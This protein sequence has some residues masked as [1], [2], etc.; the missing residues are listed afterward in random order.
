MLQRQKRMSFL[1]QIVTED[2]KW[3]YFENPK[4]R[5][6][7]LIQMNCQHARPNRFG[8]KTTLCVWWDQA[9][10]VDYELLKPGETVNTDCYRQQINL[11]HALMIKRPEWFRRHGKVTLFHDNAPSHTSKPI[12][13]TLKDLAWEVLTRH[14]HPLLLFQITT[15]FDQWHM[16][17]LS[18]TSKRMKNWKIG[19]LNGL[20]QNQKSSIGTVATNYPKDGRNV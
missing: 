6:S 20:P 15:S 2:E 18:N 12:K 11:N 4:H 10:L 13:D 17:F 5:K 8:K 3:I 19:F 1:L 16:H 14:I 9:S 7:C